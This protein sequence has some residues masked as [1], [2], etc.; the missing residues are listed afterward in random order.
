MLR[1]QKVDPP[2]QP[3]RI[4]NH[5]VNRRDHHHRRRYP[6]HQPYHLAWLGLT[7]VCLLEMNTLGSGSS[8]RSAAIIGR[9]FQ[10]ERCLSLTRRSFDALMRFEQGLGTT[11]DYRPIG[12]LLIAGPA[13]AGE[14]CRR[15][16]LLQRIGV[17]SNLVDRD[18]IDR[19]TPGLNLMGI[20]LGLHVL[21]DGEI[22][23]HS[24]MMGF[25]GYARRMGVRIIEGVEAM[26][27]EIRGERVTGVHTTAGSISTGCVV[28]AAGFRA[29]QVGRWAGMD[30]PIANLKRHLLVTGPVAGCARTT[31]FTDEVEAGWT[32]PTPRHGS[33]RDRR[34][35]AA[36]GSDRPRP[37]H[38]TC[39]APRPRPGN[40]RA[41]DQLD[42]AAAGHTGR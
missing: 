21:R 34:G 42:G 41:A 30:L 33:R 20:D 4:T 31:P 24:I 40:G 14:L 37:D 1:P 36:G 35:R 19:L 32:G 22:D 17:E 9:D 39:N 26:G 2:R 23:P 10:S 6:G 18:A 8:G 12:C 5:A 11:P 16:A 27:L 3:D 25:A 28:N 7:D 13:R 38:R 15:H 29:R